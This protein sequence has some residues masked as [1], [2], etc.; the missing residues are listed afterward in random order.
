VFFTVRPRLPRTKI[1]VFEPFLPLSPSFDPTEPVLTS[2]PFFSR[3]SY[4]I[5]S[6]APGDWPLTAICHSVRR[7]ICHISQSI[8][9]FRRERLSGRL[10]PHV[11]VV[12]PA[13]RTERASSWSLRQGQ[14]SAIHGARQ[15]VRCLRRRRKGL[16]VAVGKCKPGFLREYNGC[17]ENHRPILLHSHRVI[18]ATAR[19]PATLYFKAAV[20]HSSALPATPRTARTWPCGTRWCQPNAPWWPRSPATNQAAPPPCSSPTGEC[21]W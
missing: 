6:T 18:N 5:N 19:A 10:Y 17:V 21:N 16:P 20:P 13:E 4:G 8:T 2:S 1:L 11:G 12:S 14:P 9:Q 3:R 7:P 15:Q